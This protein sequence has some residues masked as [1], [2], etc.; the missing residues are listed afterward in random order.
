MKESLHIRLDTELTAR[1]RAYATKRGISL[2]AA[3]AV[4]LTDA[5][6]TTEDS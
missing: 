1:V 6:T 2:A 3:I 5:L 4:L